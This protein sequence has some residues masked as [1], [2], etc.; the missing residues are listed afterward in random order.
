MHRRVKFYDAGSIGLFVDDLRPGTGLHNPSEILQMHVFQWKAIS[1]RSA[2]FCR[3]LVGDMSRRCEAAKNDFVSSPWNLE[4]SRKIS[5]GQLIRFRWWHCPRQLSG[6]YSRHH[7]VQV[8]W[9]VWRS[10]LG[11]GILSDKI[12][13][14]NEFQRR[15]SGGLIAN[16]A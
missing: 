2:C 15:T 11:K 3:H 9:S 14:D 13:S 5:E 10:C 7:L 4:S 1:G 6:N 8:T 12:T 16:D